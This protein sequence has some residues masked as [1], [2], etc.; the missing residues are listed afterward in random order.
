[1]AY[2]GGNQTVYDTFR[3]AE[4]NGWLINV[5]TKWASN[6]YFRTTDRKLPH[7]YYAHSDVL[8]GARGG[9]SIPLPQFDFLAAGESNPTAVQGTIVKTR[10]GSVNSE[11]AWDP[12]SG[13]YL[14]SQRG[15]AHLDKETGHRMARESVIVLKTKYGTSSADA[16]SPEAITTW[17][18][19]EAW[20]F[21]NGTYVHGRWARQETD[22]RFTLVDD[23]E[24]GIKLSPGPVWVTLTDVSPTFG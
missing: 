2:S 19:G 16:R 15:R 17:D 13:M 3:A 21:T 4:A 6:A 9:A 18:T 10:V 5:A 1:V 14:R 8:W 12:A 20:V 24:R 22:S 11:F 23:N 7:N